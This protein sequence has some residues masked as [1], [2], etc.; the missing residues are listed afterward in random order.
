MNLEHHIGTAQGRS[1]V[2][3]L[4]T[5]KE[6]FFTEENSD[7]ESEEDAES[8]NYSV[9]QKA[10]ETHSSHMTFGNPNR[11]ISV[12]IPEES[13]EQTCMNEVPTMS[14]LERPSSGT[15]PEVPSPPNKDTIV[16]S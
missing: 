12:A 16:T 9:E 14:D 6:S 2:K 4:K 15:C 8:Q 13:P 11:E 1:T 10:F 3:N 7:Q 5:F